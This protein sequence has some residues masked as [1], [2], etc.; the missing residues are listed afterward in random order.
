MSNLSYLKP[1]A[2]TLEAMEEVNSGNMEYHLVDDD[3][4]N[5]MLNIAKDNVNA[6]KLNET[7]NSELF[8]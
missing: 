2:E 3:P 8:E 7:P 1:N 5:Q 6:K 4:A